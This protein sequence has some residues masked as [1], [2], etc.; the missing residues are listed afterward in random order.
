MINKERPELLPN[1]PKIEL[2]HRPHR[3]L[4]NQNTEKTEKQKEIMR[5]YML[6]TEWVDGNDPTGWWMSEKFD[7]LRAHWDGKI[8]WSR[9]GKVI[10]APESFTKDLPSDMP[11]DG[12]LW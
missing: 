3:S 11:L 2:T 12:E 4:F 9:S 5:S 6:C 8:L 10:N 7:G 1:A